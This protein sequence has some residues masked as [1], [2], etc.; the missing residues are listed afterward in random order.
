M[1]NEMTDQGERLKDI[2]HARSVTSLH[3]SSLHKKEIALRSHFLVTSI[4]GEPTLACIV[5]H[6][7]HSDCLGGA[8]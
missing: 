4:Q 3:E 6:S 7:A 2:T 5:P 1:G 8:V